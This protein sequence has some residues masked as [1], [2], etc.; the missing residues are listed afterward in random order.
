MKIVFCSSASFYEH[1][2]RL[3]D[4]LEQLGHESIVPDS[5]EKMK[6]SGNYDVASHKTWYDNPDDYTQKRALMDGHF[7]KVTEGDAI[8]VV[9]DDKHGQAGYIGPN[10][11]MEMA[12]AYYL[13]KPIYILNNVP[14]DSSIF[15]EVVGMGCV[16]LDGDLSK[17]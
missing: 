8:L 6:K 16:L 17:I 4:E 15:E 14:K 12:V 11:L 5:A 2:N 3:A 10:A 1:V 13:K 9:N 7:K